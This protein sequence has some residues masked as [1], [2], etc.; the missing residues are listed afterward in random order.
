MKDCAAN[1]E[2][3]SFAQLEASFGLSGV[4]SLYVFSVFLFLATLTLF[5]L[6]LV[7]LASLYRNAGQ[8]EVS[9]QSE[10]QISSVGLILSVPTVL[11]LYQML[12]VLVPQ[13]NQFLHNVIQVYE[14][15]VIHRL[16]NLTSLQLNI[17]TILKFSDLLSSL[18][19]GAEGKL[20]Y[21]QRLIKIL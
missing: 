19:S 15:V 9:S 1:G 5:I 3:P 21:W 12:T 20:K 2:I 11:S 13:A 4:V 18:W 10:L 8:A 17:G 7:R 14:A 16:Q 6:T